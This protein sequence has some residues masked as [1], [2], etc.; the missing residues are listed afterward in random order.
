MA[1][2]I[3][4]HYAQS[5]L[6]MVPVSE[7]V[8]REELDRL[9]LPLVLLQNVAVGDAQISND[10][11]GR[12]FIH[13]VRRMQAQL[14]AGQ[15]STDNALV[16]SAY[17]MMFEAM[18]HAPNLGQA[19]HRAS[20]YFQRLQENGESFY[21]EDAGD[22]VRCRF[23]FADETEHTLTSPE[24][25]AMGQL[26]WLPGEGGR[27]VSMSMWHRVC[28]WFI[29]SYIDLHAVELRQS[30]ERDKD[31]AEIFGTTVS[32]SSDC[33]VIYFHR[34]YLRFPIVQSEESLNQMLETYP[35]ELLKLDPS[36]D[37]VSGK[38]R[39]LIGTNFQRE[40]PSLQDIAERLYLTTPTL[41]RRLREEGTSF[42]KLKDICR[43]DASIKFITDGNY[44][45]GQLAELMGFSDSSTFHRAFKKWTGKTPQQYYQGLTAHPE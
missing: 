23:E 18:L 5:L 32:F 21:L 22:Y 10:D 35:A 33:D 8:L 7:E 6:R 12:L 15:G 9:K 25:Y 37:S 26:H 4:L 36:D 16:Y 31:C 2:T 27:L 24:I 14:P 11:Y 34:R 3:P 43:R 30:G 41:H 20:V 28:S 38:V 40:L 29:G 19:M 13:L 1:D 45:T 17:R 39:R 44:T 42:Q